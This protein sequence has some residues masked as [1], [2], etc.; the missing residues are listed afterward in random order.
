MQVS[1]NFLAPS[2]FT[3]RFTASW[4]KAQKRFLKIERKQAYNQAG[5]ESYD[6][7][8]RGSHEEARRLLRAEL[9]HQRDMYAAARARGLA[10][11][12]LRQFEE[13]LSEYLRDYE[14]PSYFVSEELGEEIWFARPNHAADEL[15]DC[16]IFDSDVMFVNTYDGLDRLAGAV[17]IRDKEQIALAAAEA[18]Q[19]LSH[20][21]RLSDFVASHPL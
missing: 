8:V 9:L 17:E 2:D 4:D 14:M 11:V 15:P 10:L 16:I 12:R 20:A 7:F 5:D 13:P 19:L 6:A 21:E 1:G 18:E 3:E